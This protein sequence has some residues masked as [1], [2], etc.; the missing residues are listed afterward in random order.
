MIG[1]FSSWAI[2][3]TSSARADTGCGAVTA[4]AG[5][6]AGGRVLDRREVKTQTASPPAS[7]PRIRPTSSGVTVEV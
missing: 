4:P 7:V 6:S 3:D 5:A 1:F 2:L